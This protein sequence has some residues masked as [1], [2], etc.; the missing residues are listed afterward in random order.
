MTIKEPRITV[1]FG[2][3]NAEWRKRRRKM[4]R[5]CE[6]WVAKRWHRRLLWRWQDRTVKGIHLR[7]AFA[8]VSLYVS[9][10]FGG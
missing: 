1:S 6:G 2:F 9:G 3:R 5:R 8:E 10:P 4:I 7:G